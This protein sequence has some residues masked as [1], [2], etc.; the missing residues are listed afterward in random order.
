MRAAL[1]DIDVVKKEQQ[2]RSRE[3]LQQEAPQ[4][5]SQ[6]A[7]TH[8]SHSSTPAKRTEP[9]RFYS[10]SDKSNI[11]SRN[12]S[13]L[14]HSI[15]GVSAQAEIVRHY[16]IALAKAESIEKECGNRTSLVEQMERLVAGIQAL[17]HVNSHHDREATIEGAK[18]GRSVHP[19]ETSNSSSSSSSSSSS[20]IGDNTVWMGT[21]HRAKGHEWR[22]VIVVDADH[23]TY[24]DGDRKG[25]SM[26]GYRDDA[27]NLLFVAISRAQQNV[28]LAYAGQT[29]AEP[30]ELS[31]LLRPIAQSSASTDVVISQYQMKTDVNE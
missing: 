28:T 18:K 12:S 3:Q 31:R 13:D 23:D 6:A 8:V 24:K 15:L 19:M 27:K 1:S 14:G 21:I 2:T 11:S 30:R 10:A 9:S 29:S 5:R 20:D 25:D 4:S 26:L 16:D 17:E 7:T 22:H